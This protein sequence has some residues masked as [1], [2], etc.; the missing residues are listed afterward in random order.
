MEWYYLD[1][2]KVI[3]PIDQKD[4]VRLAHEGFILPSTNVSPG[5][6]GKWRLAGKIRGLFPN[7][8]IV[9]PKP[10]T[11]DGPILFAD[12][13]EPLQVLPV[14][15]KQ[16]APSSVPHGEPLQVSEQP[17][18]EPRKPR[19]LFDMEEVEAEIPTLHAAGCGCV[20][21]AML[22]MAMFLGAINV[23]NQNSGNGLL[24]AMPVVV[25]IVGLVVAP[26]LFWF[27]RKHG[28]RKLLRIEVNEEKDGRPF[29]T[30]TLH[31][32]HFFLGLKTIQKKTPVNELCYIAIEENEFGEIAK[33]RNRSG[34]ISFPLV[35][36]AIGKTVTQL[37]TNI[38]DLIG[39]PL[40]HSES[41]TGKM[42]FVGL[43]RDKQREYTLR[44]ND[45]ALVLQIQS[46]NGKPIPGIPKRIDLARVDS[47][48]AREGE[49]LGSYLTHLLIFLIAVISG[50]G[51][52][53]IFL[54]GL[55]SYRIMPNVSFNMAG[56]EINIISIPFSDND[57]LN[58]FVNFLEKE[59]E[60]DVE[61]INT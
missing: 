11:K 34:K 58:E 50:C 59:A 6:P 7:Q 57:Q 53:V 54:L 3:G 35:T 23:A 36:G 13:D 15:Q 28:S 2:E 44:G 14:R 52:I 31:V 27:A 1:G 12:D 60:M 19:K 5:K 21:W 47:I 17:R 61:W 40:E 56:K 22:T 55:R 20:L 10:E 41:V 46:L 26:I 48:T 43:L 29:R 8:P 38:S 24:N 16:T 30:G 49:S 39:I 45:D 51:L 25:F 42:S 18:E 9:Q 37:A 32:E 33:L 4:L